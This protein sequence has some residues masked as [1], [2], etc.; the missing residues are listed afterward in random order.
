MEPEALGHKPL[1]R[2]GVVKAFHSLTHC[3]SAVGLNAS[4]RACSEP[5]EAPLADAICEFITASVAHFKHRRP[6]TSTMTN[7]DEPD[8]LRFIHSA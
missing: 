7:K 3:T 4:N 1:L 6:E 8:V 5:E 2:D